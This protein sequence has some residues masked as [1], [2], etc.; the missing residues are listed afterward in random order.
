MIVEGNNKLR[1]V[2]GLSPTCKVR[3]IN[4]IHSLV[5]IWLIER[6]PQSTFRAGNLMGRQI[7]ETWE[8]TPLNPLFELYFDKEKNNCAYAIRQAGIAAG[9]LLKQVIAADPHRFRFN[10]GFKNSYTLL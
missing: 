4:F 2:R 9:Y 3:A 5:K 8:H 7:F 10:R 6:R 1:N